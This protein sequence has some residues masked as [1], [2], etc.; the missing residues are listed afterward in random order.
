MTPAFS[1]VYGGKGYGKLK[2]SAIYQNLPE[3]ELWSFVIKPA[4]RLD[5]APILRTLGDIRSIAAEFVEC[6]TWLSKDLAGFPA[7]PAPLA[8]SSETRSTKRS[9]LHGLLSSYPIYS[10]LASPYHADKKQAGE[11]AKAALLV[12]IVQGGKVATGSQQA[13]L[14]EIAGRAVRRI[15]LNNSLHH[16]AEPV[17]RRDHDSLIGLATDLLSR[18]E[19]E[20][21]AEERD[22]EVLATFARLILYACEKRV[23]P[24]REAGAPGVGSTRAGSLEEEAEEPDAPLPQP[25]LT[26]APLS[27]QIRIART[28]QAAAPVREGPARLD[29]KSDVTPQAGR[30]NSRMIL[31]KARTRARAVAASAQHLAHA[32][33]R[34]QHLDLVALFRWCLQEFGADRKQQASRAVADLLVTML[35]TGRPFEVALQAAVAG[36]TVSIDAGCS[37]LKVLPEPLGWLLPGPSLPDAFRPGEEEQALYRPVCGHLLLPLPLVFA[38][39]HARLNRRPGE[40]LFQGSPDQWE[41]WAQKALAQ[42]NKSS[43][44]RLTLHRIAEFLSEFTNFVEGDRAESA[45]YSAR[46]DA[47]GCAARHYYYA[48]AAQRIVDIYRQVWDAVA[49]SM[50]KLLGDLR[51]NWTTLPADYAGRSIGSRGCPRGE[52]V[53]QDLSGLY[54]RT[55]AIVKRPGRPNPQHLQNLHNALTAY[56]V[57]LAMWI[58]ALRAVTEPLSLELIDAEQGYLAV[59]EKD[60]EDYALSRVVWLPEV[61]REQFQHYAVHRRILLTRRRKFGMR[62]LRRLPESWCFFIVDELAVPVTP[63]RLAEVLGDEYRLRLNAQRHYLRTVLREEGV[64]GAVVDALLGHGAFGEEPYA[65]YSVFSPRVMRDELSKVLPKLLEQMGWQAISGLTK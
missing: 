31:L 3:S 34:L 13:S 44:A 15:C 10:A 51:W 1:S 50:P 18:L 19:Q 47:T 7:P 52:I 14:R 36:D 65:R 9:A 42:I 5:H 28:E 6:P 32:S 49:A 58:G 35:L 61:G 63:K 56:T 2:V 26:P 43:G 39:L 30:S 8:L 60:S 4:G 40:P 24:Q 17:L 48:P 41:K 62:R 23:P 46:Q 53:K 12:A 38:G 64:S 54:T 37:G 27:E 29:F 16:L 25:A 59:S 57:T 11:R 33:D 55:L 21:G 22:R 20:H 45:Y